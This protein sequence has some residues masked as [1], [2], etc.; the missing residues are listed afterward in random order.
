MPKSFVRLWFAVCF[1]NL[2]FVLLSFFFGGSAPVFEYFSLIPQSLYGLIFVILF[3][4]AFLKM[5][6]KPVFMAIPI[7][8]T[9]LCLILIEDVVWLNM[10]DRGS[11]GGYSLRVV[12]WNTELWSKSREGA[13]FKELKNKEADVYLLQEVFGARTAGI[14]DRV[15]KEFS[16]YYVSH[17]GEFLTISRYPVLSSTLSFSA[18]YLITRVKVNEKTISFYNI[19]LKTPLLG[20]KKE[21]DNKYIFFARQG[22]FTDLERDIYKDKNEVFLAGDFNSTRNYPFIRQMENT[23]TMNQPAGMLIFPKTF[24]TRL[25]AIR[26]DYQFTSKKNRFVNYSLFGGTI[27]DHFGVYGEFYDND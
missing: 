1:I 21:E 15:R 5:P 18:G 8:G 22:Q 11:S 13:Y 7:I 9:V 6:K 4:T 17:Q 26:I 10:T 14:E 12:N 24:S 3:F 19:H 20:D 27:S 25:P 23:F 2:L 16:N